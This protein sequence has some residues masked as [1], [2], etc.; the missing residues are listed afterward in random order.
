MA[1]KQALDYASTYFKDK[2]IQLGE[3]FSG[4]TINV[5][6]QYSTIRLE[7]VDFNNLQKRSLSLIMRQEYI[8][9]ELRTFIET[10]LPPMF[11]IIY[12][13]REGICQKYEVEFGQAIPEEYKQDDDK[14]F[15]LYVSGC[16]TDPPRSQL[17]A[18]RSEI[19][20]LKY[21]VE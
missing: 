19:T 21:Q 18:Y 8:I 15:D 3:A 4:E 6:K 16:T 7:N 2:S 5:L 10:I 13:Q 20:N 9:T 17:V 14:I 1:R 12:T 11:E